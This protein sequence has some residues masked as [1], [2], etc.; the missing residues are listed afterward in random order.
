MKGDKL[1]LKIQAAQELLKSGT[2]FGTVDKHPGGYYWRASF[3]VDGK[4]VD[5]Y[6]QRY[7]SA[8][9][10]MRVHYV[11]IH[12]RKGYSS[13]TVSELRLLTSRKA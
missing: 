1:K 6:F 4:I 13:L 12:W 8:R 7:A 3:E 11:D 2:L 9:K 10:A 5:V